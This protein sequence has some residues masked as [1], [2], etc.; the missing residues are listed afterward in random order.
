MHMESETAFQDAR[1][2]YIIDDDAEVRKSLHR[3]LALMGINASPFRSGGDFLDGLGDLK[4]APILVDIHMPEVDGLAFMSELRRREKAW[5]VIAMTGQSEVPT[6]VKAMRLG[7]IEFLSKPF[8]VDA[9]ESAVDLA[10][11][12]LRD[13]VARERQRNAALAR[14]AALTQR[15][16]EVARELA[17]GLSNKQIARALDLSVRTVEMHRAHAMRKLE[18]GNVVELVA[19]AIAAGGTD[20]AFLRQSSE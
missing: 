4:P 3:L 7:A 14:F 1:E 18:A 5:P 8:E 13:R 17:S 19:L 6:A 20:A 12:T 11:D 10:F 16:S 9:L 15:E 2:I